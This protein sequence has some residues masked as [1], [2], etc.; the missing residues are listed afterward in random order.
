MINNLARI[1]RQIDP[2]YRKV[3]KYNNQKSFNSTSYWKIERSG[4]FSIVRD[5]FSKFKE[6]VGLK[7]AEN[8]PGKLKGIE[9]KFNSLKKTENKSIKNILEYWLKFCKNLVSEK[10]PNT[11]KIA[12][13]IVKYECTYNSSDRS[14][15]LLLPNEEM[16]NFIIHAQKMTYCFL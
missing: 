4:Y 5:Y 7:K 2:S 10:N 1:A 11:K 14:S 6:A 13:A 8:E 15:P 16:L 9:N 3:Y 12:N